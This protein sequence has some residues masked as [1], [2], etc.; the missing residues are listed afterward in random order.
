MIRILR[1]AVLIVALPA[2][3]ARHEARTLPLDH[4]ANPQAAEA[5]LPEQ[6]HTLD[7][8]EVRPRGA[9]NGALSPAAHEHGAKHHND[10]AEVAPRE[11]EHSS[12]QPAAQGDTRLYACRMHPEVTSV[13]PGRCPKCGMK[14]VKTDATEG[15]P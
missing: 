9:E 5:R 15:H 2:C 8:A 1:T 14:L 11:H 13:E 4:P 7:P 12:M 6:S 3:V 10:G